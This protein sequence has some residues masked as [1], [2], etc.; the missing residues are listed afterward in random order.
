MR[1][2][3]SHRRYCFVA[4]YPLAVW[5]C[6]FTGVSVHD[7]VFDFQQPCLLL[8][9]VPVQGLVRLLLRSGEAEVQQT[10]LYCGE[11][12]FVEVLVTSTTATSTTVTSASSVSLRSMSSIVGPSAHISRIL[13]T[14]Q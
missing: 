11:G 10:L 6:L 8:P 4:K 7:S 1:L 14:N 2:N 9:K 13:A 5:D 3:N 12:L